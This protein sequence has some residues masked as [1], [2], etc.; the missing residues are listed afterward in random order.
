MATEYKLSYT[1]AEINE[2]L[3]KVDE[4]SEAIDELKENG[5][6]GGIK[7][8]TDPTVPAWAKEPEKPKYTASEVGARPSTWTPSA[9]DVGA[10]A[11]GTADSKVTAHN[12]SDESHNDIRLLL[13]GL[14]T[15][16]N[17]LANSTD[18]DL[19]QLAEIVAYI[20][21]N[22]SLIDSITTS[23]VNVADIIDN[24]TT[25]VSN[26]PLSAKM[27]VQLKALIDAIE[28][29]TTLPASDVY[30]W[31]KQPQK[32]TY[33]AGE[34][35]AASAEKVAE[36]SEAI[37]D[38]GGAKS[39]VDSAVGATYPPAQRPA[40]M[41]FDGYDINIL[42]STADNVYTYIDNVVSG[43]ETV[44][45][46]ILGK[47]ASGQYDIARYIYANREYCAWVR[48]NYPKMYA[49]KNGSAIRYTTSVSPRINDRA[50]S[51]PYIE[52]SG[53]QTVTVP[54][55]AC[56]AVGLR[57]SQSGGAFSAES[58][59][60]SVILPLPKNPTQAPVIALEGMTMHTVRTYVY[61]GTEP[62]SFPTTIGKTMNSDNSGF[63]VITD[64]DVLKNYSYIVFFVA[65]TGTS[66]E[67]ANAKI[68]LDGVEMA[69]ETTTDIN[70]IGSIAT[71]ETTTTVTTE[72]GGTPITAVSATNRS[73]TIGGVEYVRYAD[74]DVAPTVIYTAIDDNRNSGTTITQ[75]G[76]TYNRYPLGD[77]G[78]NREK[79]IPVFIYANE[80]GVIKDITS[81]ENHEGKM[82][83]L[84]AARLLRDIVSGAQ[85][86]NPLY[87]YFRD[88]CMLI[89]IP[90]ANPFGFNY[91]VSS[92]VNTVGNGYYNANSVN[93]NRNYD[94]PGWDVFKS[95]NPGS[96]MGAYP[97]SEI[98]TQYIMNT[99]VES[100]AVVAMSLHGYASGNG[101]C[102]HQGQNPGN[103]DYDQDKLAKI[104]AFLETNWGYS[105]VYYDEAPLMN[106]PDITSKSP[107]YITQCGS[108][109]GIVEIS[110][111]DNRTS[112]LK[113]EANQHVCENAYAQVI[114]LTAMWL[115]DYLEA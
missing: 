74:G 76:I 82:P 88:N 80:H 30:S 111:D 97:G 66:G 63:T 89:V 18:E 108:Y 112:G 10:D 59:V 106:T 105:L 78:S 69:F 75:D 8:E 107:S 24:L 79:L 65:S 98:E 113:Q 42:D 90:V 43:K 27:G 56:V 52:T 61:G 37:A 3:G 39:M 110:P 87:Q 13:S 77:L 2:K 4:L 54:A 21:A 73:R 53:T 95:E 62:T 55:K 81:S 20:K 26:K 91:N 104:N 22:K 49:W 15:R 99:M 101:K 36:L 17:A 83:A 109:G 38:L 31:A 7:E 34:V 51:S 35:G 86:K 19:D 1:G 103:V 72:G 44:T 28:I 58:G 14:T 100:G 96:A 29:P 46:E 102:A 50:Y 41:E 93:I 67:Y 40:A 5:T 64:L 94:T 6:G 68:L 48:E 92:D 84:V 9:E 16:L 11:S 25:S 115:S 23:K 114:N 12:T 60:S 45:K 57:Y 70:A 71:Q 47:D 85:A 33:T 32:P